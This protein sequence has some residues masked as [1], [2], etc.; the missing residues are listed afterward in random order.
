MRSSPQWGYAHEPKVGRKDMA[1]TVGRKDQ[2]WITGAEYH[3][4]VKTTKSSAPLF[5][6]FEKRAH[7]ENQRGTRP[8]AR[9]R[10]NSFPRDDFSESPSDR[11]CSNLRIARCTLPLSRARSR[12]EMPARASLIRRRIW[13]LLRVLR[14]KRGAVRGSATEQ[15]KGAREL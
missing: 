15:R 1:L 12:S 2:G 4:G 3:E 8:G 10:L 7:L 5:P 9:I 6:L 14:V 13:I 11:E